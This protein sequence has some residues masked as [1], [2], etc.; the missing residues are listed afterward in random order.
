MEGDLPESVLWRK[1]AKFW[2]GAGVEE[3]LSEYAEK[4]VSDSDFRSERVIGTDLKL[5]SK[6]E[7][8]YYRH[9]KE[10]F[11][12]LPDLDWMGRTKGAPGAE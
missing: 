10:Y 4:N 7:L 2:E 12:S 9:F 6:E 5:N 8:L 1:K 3:I 11:G